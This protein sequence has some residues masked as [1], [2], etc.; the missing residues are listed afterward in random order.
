[1]CKYVF[2]VS[3]FVLTVVVCR[4]SLVVNENCACKN[5]FCLTRNYMGRGSFGKERSG[6]WPGLTRH[7]Q[8]QSSLGKCCSGNWFCLKRHYC[9]KR[10]IWKGLHRIG[11]G[12]GSVH[13]SASLPCGAI[14]GKFFQPKWLNERVR[15][16]HHSCAN[17]GFGKACRVWIDTTKLV[18]R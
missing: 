3:I 2:Y 12:E 8:E 4:A 5:W 16:K 13:H 11:M 15:S 14:S 18:Q 7:Y 17:E 10:F 9:E 6:N 1:M